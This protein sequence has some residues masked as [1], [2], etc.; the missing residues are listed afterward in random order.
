MYDIPT[1]KAALKTRIAHKRYEHSLRVCDEAVK[2]AIHYRADVERA[3]VA[4]LM[5]DVCKGSEKMAMERYADLIDRTDARFFT[6]QTRHAPLAALVLREE[7]G[8]DDQEIL[9]AVTCHT[10]GRPDMSSLDMI[11]FIADAIEPGR[12]YPTVEKLRRL[13]Y[14][15]LDAA[16]LTSLS[17]TLVHLVEKNAEIEPDTILARNS[18]IK[19]GVKYVR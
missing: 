5:H 8:I 2:L 19:K 15:D 4:G 12:N 3:R 1:L 18:L 16:V 6:K 7:F 13:A 17:E 14:E 11:V 9:E 10:T